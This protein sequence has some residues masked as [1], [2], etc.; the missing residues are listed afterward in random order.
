MKRG[1]TQPFAIAIGRQLGAGGKAVAEQL[2]A[3]LGVA[4]YDRRLIELAAQAQGFDAQRVREVDEVAAQGMT[5]K[6]LRAIASPFAGFRNPYDNPLSHESVF[7]VQAEVIR[8]IA[9]RESAVFVG[10]CSDYI[11]RDHPRHVSVFVLADMADRVKAVSARLGISE[12]AAREMVARNDRQRA[13]HHNLYAETTWGMAAA[14]DL[15]VNVSRLGIA[16]AA[17]VALHFVRRALG[18]DDLP[19]VR[20]ANP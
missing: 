19:P 18:E 10:R 20:S 12:A 4:V 16:D 14:Y 17:A 9:A 5:S 2:A 13:A 7:S 8:G 11:L 1:E 15:C 3:A 6:L